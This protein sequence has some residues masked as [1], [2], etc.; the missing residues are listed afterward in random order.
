VN[1][2]ERLALLRTGLDE[3]RK[4][5]HLP[6][7]RLGFVEF[8]LDRAGEFIAVGRL[9]EADGV[10][11]RAQTWLERNQPSNPEVTASSKATDDPYWDAPIVAGN[12]E[13]LRADLQ[14]KKRLVPAPERE[15]FQQGLQRVE[16]L[17]SQRKVRKAREEL[18]VVR[19][20]LIRRLQRSYRARAHAQPLVRG[21]DGVIKV[22]PRR[23]RSNLQPVGPYNNQRLLEDVVAL[24]G[25]RDP[26]WV[27]D[28]AELYSSLQGY[29]ERLGN[30]EKQVRKA[31]AT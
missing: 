13:R 29:V 9:P 24:V 18:A 31:K 12:V 6:Y 5:S 21:A 22:S 25:E 3:F 1:A 14:R 30:P 11:L 16:H 4:T 8:L 27:E 17:L 7:W 10:L 28:F 20:N 26:I 23:E 19:T 15:A 2:H